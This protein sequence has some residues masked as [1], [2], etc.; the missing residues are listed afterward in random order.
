V[1]W[2]VRA[3]EQA[4][5]GT[6]PNPSANLAGEE[7]I[8]GDS[9][10]TKSLRMIR[11]NLHQA[12]NRSA[13]RGPHAVPV[14]VRAVIARDPTSAGASQRI[15]CGLFSACEI[16]RDEGSMGTIHVG[17]GFATGRPL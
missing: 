2:L 11:S 16:R 5:G 3:S 7:Q 12:Y 4:I 10:P 1:N 13:K 9:S 17:I 8:A 14:W 6:P 15:A